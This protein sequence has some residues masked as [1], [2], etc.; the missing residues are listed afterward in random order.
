MK[1]IVA[2]LL[3]VTPA[4]A[5]ADKDLE[6][7]A[8]WNCADDATVNI[9]E[10]DATYTLKGECKTVSVNSTNATVVGESIDELNINGSTNKVTVATLGTTNINGTKNKVTWKAAKTGKKPAVNANGTGNA[11]TQDKSKPKK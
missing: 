1:C 4:V 8:T 11:V 6:K 9:V 5:W 10:G 2:L 7:G 3:A